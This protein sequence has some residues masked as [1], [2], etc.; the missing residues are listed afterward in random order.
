MDTRF[1]TFLPA[2]TTPILNILVEEFTPP[3]TSIPSK[4]RNHQR[5]ASFCLQTGIGEFQR[6]LWYGHLCFICEPSTVSVIQQG[7]KTLSLP[8]L[9]LV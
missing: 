6:Y 9:D 2:A 3:G 8:C 1:A 7:I 4:A 5:Q